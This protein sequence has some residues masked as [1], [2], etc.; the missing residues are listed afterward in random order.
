[1][2]HFPLTFTRFSRVEITL[3]DKSCLAA[4]PSETMCYFR[5][6]WSVGD[7][8]C[9]GYYYDRDPYKDFKLRVLIYMTIVLLAEL[10]L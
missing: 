2:Y 3:S 5:H 10:L 6:R 8:F 7:L 4:M 1:V 9:S